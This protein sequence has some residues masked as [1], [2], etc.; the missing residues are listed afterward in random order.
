[1]GELPTPTKTSAVFLG[2]W[3]EITGGAELKSTT[4]YNINGDKTYYAHW[5]VDVM[6]QLDT[7]YGSVS[8][9]YNNP[10]WNVGG[11]HAPKIKKITSG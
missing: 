2:W 3:T 6:V 10:S 9:P 11:G 7:N 8:Y 5:R 1:M 4:V